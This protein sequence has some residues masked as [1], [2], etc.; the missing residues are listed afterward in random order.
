MNDT[1]KLIKD[2]IESTIRKTYHTEVIVEY[3]DNVDKKVQKIENQCGSKLSSVYEAANLAGT[4]IP[5][6]NG[7]PYYIIIKRNQNDMK[8]VMTAF[9]EYQHLK[10]YIQFINTVFDGDIETMKKSPLYATF[11]VY[12]EYSATLFGTQQY[13]KI[14]SFEGMTQSEIATLHL[15]QAK[16]AYCDFT[17]IKNRYQLLIH[18]LSFC[19][20]LMACNEFVDDL[21]VNNYLDEMELADEIKPILFNILNFNAT[22]DWYKLNDRMMRAFVDGGIES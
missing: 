15:Q 17:S 8:Y 21:N 9:H 19:G 6:V 1:Q 7:N 20:E 2:T 3:V 18:S 10:D 22:S 11:N 13:F 4:F 5:A 14:V 16:S 12:S